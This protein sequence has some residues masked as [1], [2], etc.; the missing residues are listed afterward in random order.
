M[1]IRRLAAAADILTPPLLAAEVPTTPGTATS[2]TVLFRWLMAHFG[3]QF[4]RAASDADLL[5]FDFQ[6]G[7]LVWARILDDI[8]HP[9]H[10]RSLRHRRAHPQIAGLGLMAAAFYAAA[11]L[12]IQKA[13]FGNRQRNRIFLRHSGALLCREG[14]SNAAGWRYTSFSE[15]PAEWRSPAASTWRRWA[16]VIVVSAAFQAMPLSAFDARLSRSQRQAIVVRQLAGL[17]L[18]GIGA[19]PRFP[20]L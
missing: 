6:G 8:R 2:F 9:Q 16:G 7:H 14:R 12:A 10:P 20:H 3:S 19:V 11:P 13:H 15:L 1:S 4:I 18:A 5:F 17:L